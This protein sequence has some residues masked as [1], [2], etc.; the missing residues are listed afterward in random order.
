MKEKQKEHIRNIKKNENQNYSGKSIN[1]NENLKE[2]R[3]TEKIWKKKP[4]TNANLM[5]NKIT[6][7]KLIA[8]KYKINCFSETHLSAWNVK[9]AEI[10]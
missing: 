5:R 1:A 7:L 10:A 8:S 4:Y 6:Q 9:E 2:K 3:K